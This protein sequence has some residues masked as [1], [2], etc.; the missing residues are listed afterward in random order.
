MEASLIESSVNKHG[1]VLAHHISHFDEEFYRDDVFCCSFILWEVFHDLVY[2]HFGN[3]SS[4]LII[5]STSD[6]H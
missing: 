1:D 2:L 5:L 6:L 4:E 3:G